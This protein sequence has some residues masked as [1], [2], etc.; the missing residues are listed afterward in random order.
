MVG[1]LAYETRHGLEEKDNG[2]G[3]EEDCGG[4]VDN[5][6]KYQGEVEDEGCPALVTEV[7]SK[8]E[9]LGVG[10]EAHLEGPV[11]KGL[12]LGV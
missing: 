11:G 12:N 7:S 9:V 10:A 6:R 2:E 5:G 8:L 3:G 1:A 4:G